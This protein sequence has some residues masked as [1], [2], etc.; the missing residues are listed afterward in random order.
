[1][2]VPRRRRGDGNGVGAEEGRHNKKR[3]ALCQP[4]GEQTACPTNQMATHS[5]REERQKRQ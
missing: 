2:E 5:K 3:C 1:M 4:K